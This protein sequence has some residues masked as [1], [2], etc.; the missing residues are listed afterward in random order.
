M[1]VDL[2]DHTT[3]DMPATPV[4]VH[5][6]AWHAERRQGLGAS[7]IGV[8]LGLSTFQSPWSL[9]AEKV[10]L[11]THD[12]AAETERQMIGREMEPVLAGLFQARTGLYVTGEQAMCR[13]QGTPWRCTVDGFVTGDPSEGSE[14]LGVVEFKT[15]GRFGWP[16]G[17]PPSYRAQII[18]QMAVT[19]LRHAWVAVMFAG[20]RF[21]VFDL[22]WDAEVEADWAFMAAKAEWFWGLVQTGIA[23]DVDG[24]TATTQA[25][26]DVWPH[27]TTGDTIEATP[28]LLELFE[29]RSAIKA[30]VA[31][32]QK[33]VR[34]ADNIIAATIGDNDT[35][36]VDGVPVWSYRAQT[37]VT[38]DA[39]TLGS[40]HPELDLDLYTTSTTFR[41]LRHVKEKTK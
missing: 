34:E 28:D 3:G 40:A 27:E 36:T 33:V 13:K 15:D 14:R 20:F 38:F 1:S 23:P 35:V 4:A 17:I 2:D 6:P 9:W 12:P 26:A 7:E 41:V 24:S 39:K 10:G 37:R 25:I 22:G 29:R 18:W 30:R 5:S 19:G 8:L 11:I 21:E 32:D 31:A 16:D